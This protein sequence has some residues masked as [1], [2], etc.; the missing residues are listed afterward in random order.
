MRPA[1]VLY[2]GERASLVDFGGS[3]LDDPAACAPDIAGF[4]DLVIYLRYSTYAGPQSRSGSSGWR[5]ELDLSPE[6]R[7]L[8]DEAL[9]HP[10][11]LSM[12]DVRDRFA[13]AFGTS[14]AR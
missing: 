9:A 8:L 12:A 3:V 1:N 11:R 14:A 7:S 13:E 2:D 10:E 4:A 5:D 6:Q